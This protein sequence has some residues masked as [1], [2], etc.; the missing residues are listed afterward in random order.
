MEF[1]ESGKII[2]SFQII[3]LIL[4]FQFPVRVLFLP[5]K[6]NKRIKTLVQSNLSDPKDFKII[7][8]LLFLKIASVT[9]QRMPKH[10]ACSRSTEFSISSRVLTVLHH[11]AFQLP[12]YLSSQ[13]LCLPT[14]PCLLRLIATQSISK[15]RSNNN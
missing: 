14:N 3:V 8:G 10:H 11:F 15:Q 12:I 9:V 7:L 1:V 13:H 5:I 4:V 2:L 6:R